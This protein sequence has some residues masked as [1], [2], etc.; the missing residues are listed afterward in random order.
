MNFYLNRNLL[1]LYSSPFILLK[2]LLNLN[3]LFLEIR[4]NNL[5]KYLNSMLPSALY[6]ETHYDKC[7]QTLLDKSFFK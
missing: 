7:N 4:L 1:S 6:A 3:N 5:K 2:Y